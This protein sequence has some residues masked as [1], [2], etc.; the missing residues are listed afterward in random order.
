MRDTGWIVQPR[1]TGDG[2]RMLRNPGW[3]LDSSGWTLVFLPAITGFISGFLGS[4]VTFFWWR[5]RSINE[6]L[7]VASLLT[8]PNK[9]QHI[10]IGVS[11]QTLWIIRAFGAGVRHSVETGKRGPSGPAG[12][13]R[14][15]ILR[16][17]WAER[18]SP[19][20]FDQRL[21]YLHDL[22]LWSRTSA[23]LIIFD[24]HHFV[25]AGIYH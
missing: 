18:S 13:E 9:S 2:G 19:G 17:L 1:R 24:Q 3:A 16:D 11:S 14:C 6:Q 12:T 10:R 20:S 4:R 23:I 25:A 8:R 5:W 22:G 15:V 21:S 7:R